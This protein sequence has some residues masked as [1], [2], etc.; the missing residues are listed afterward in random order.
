[1]HGQKQVGGSAV[2]S[3]D[4]NTAYKDAWIEKLLEN[5]ALSSKFKRFSL[6][7]G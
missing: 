6:C 7:S 5:F 1:M 2:D 3:S 4:T